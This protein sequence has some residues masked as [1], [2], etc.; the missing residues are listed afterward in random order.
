M[1]NINTF[2]IFEKCTLFVKP[3]EREDIKQK[4]R[5][6]L[7]YLITGIKINRPDKPKE[8]FYCET[9]RSSDYMCGLEG[10]KFEEK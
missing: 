8:Y 2:S 1:K 7:Q 10:H 5:D 9:A 4:E 6:Y 3:E